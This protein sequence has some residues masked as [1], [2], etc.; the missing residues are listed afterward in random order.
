M[1]KTRL[2]KSALR[3]C[4][5]A[6]LGFTAIASAATYDAVA[7]FSSISNP[8]GPW[9]YGQ[10]ATLG[11]SFSLLTTGSCGSLAG[12]Q[13]AGNVPWVLG[14]PTGGTCG[15]GVDPANMLDLHPGI[16]GELSV[17][18][19]TVPTTG[20]YTIA[21]GFQGIDRAPTTTDVH[22]LINGS[23][24]VFAGN[25]NSFGV[26]VP[27]STVQTLSAGTTVDF[28]VGL[29]TDGGAPN[30]S[31]GLQATLTSSAIPEPGSLALLGT[32][33]ALLAG[34]RRKR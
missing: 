24:S 20:V 22:V 13:S 8:N 21:G 19:F 6:A 25:V 2:I 16:N 34:I 14:S 30:D 28:A 12:W 17:V 32:G 15:T 33:L 4:S 18:R 23:T 31:T 27:F 10:T 9:S 7:A 1:M 26:L 5:V 11:G 29:G 3:V